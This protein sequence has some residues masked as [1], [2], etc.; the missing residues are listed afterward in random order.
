LSLQQE[1]AIQ[2]IAI[3]VA[4]RAKELCPIQGRA[5]DSIA[6]AAIYMACAAAGEK[7]PMKGNVIRNENDENLN[8][9]NMS[10][11]HVEL[12]RYSTRCWRHGKYDSIN[13][14]YHVA[15]SK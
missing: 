1:H 4:E 15:Q 14:S 5:P 13:L 3:F 2:R 6:G 7:K 9:L 12:Y 11:D 8:V 10:C